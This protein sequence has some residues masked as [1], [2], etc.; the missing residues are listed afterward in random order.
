MSELFDEHDLFGTGLEPAQNFSITDLDSL[1]WAFRKM[2]A[3]KAKQNEVNELAKKELERIQ[4]WQEKELR[5]TNDQFN[6][7]QGLIHDYHLRQLL[8]DPK[9]K[10]LSTPYGKSKSRFSSPAAEKV[11]EKKLLEYV[12]END[13]PYVKKSLDWGEFKKSLKVVAKGDGFVAVDE[14]GT[15]VDGVIVQPE[16]TTFSVEVE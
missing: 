3:M 11:D 5:K 9:A 8:N 12:I 1:N 7:F 15:I 16:K 6:Y 2:S 14:N 13:M 4:Y 10:T